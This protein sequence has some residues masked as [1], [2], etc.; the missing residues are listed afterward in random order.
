MSV[1]RTTVSP[2]GQTK[3]EMVEQT[4]PQGKCTAHTGTICPLP[5]EAAQGHLSCWSPLLHG[6]I[7][8]SYHFHSSPGL[9]KHLHCLHTLPHLS[10]LR[11]FSV[12][13]QVTLH[14]KEWNHVNSITHL[15]HLSY[16]PN[17]MHSWKQ[18]TS[19][20]L[21][22][23]QAVSTLSSGL[24]PLALPSALRSTV[25]HGGKHADNMACA[26][27]CFFLSFRTQIKC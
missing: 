2:C 20:F 17:V 23:P 13:W 4:S 7:P 25:I 3:P 24:W 8:L 19:S 22:Y 12:Q 6:L 26:R 18:Y 9:L 1:N 15:P 27:P 14:Q 21:P 10:L 16:N 11:P 5:D